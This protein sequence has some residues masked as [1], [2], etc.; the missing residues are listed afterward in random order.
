MFKFITIGMTLCAITFGFSNVYPSETS[1]KNNVIAE[2]ELTEIKNKLT[3][4]P[5]LIILCYKGA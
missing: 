2:F 1:T 4:E 5:K 3:N